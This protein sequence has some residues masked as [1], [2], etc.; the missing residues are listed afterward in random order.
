M[1]VFVDAITLSH[2]FFCYISDEARAEI[3]ARLE[4]KKSKI[5][6]FHENGREVFGAIFDLDAGDFLHVREVG[7]RFPRYYKILD[8]LAAFAAKGT[9]KKFVSFRTTVKGVKRLAKRAGYFLD[10]TGDFVRQAMQ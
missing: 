5:V 7:G 2:P 4:Q 9:G 3:A 1:K 8:S 6:S 10:E